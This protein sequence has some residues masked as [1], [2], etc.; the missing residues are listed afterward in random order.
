MKILIVPT[1]PIRRT[2]IYRI[3]G[4]IYGYTNVITGPLILGHILKK[5]RT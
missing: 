1:A 5:C 3:G 4:S 2:P